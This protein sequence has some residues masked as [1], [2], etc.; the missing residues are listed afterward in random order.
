MMKKLTHRGPDDTG[1]YQSINENIFLGHCRLAVLDIEGGSQPMWS[2]DGDCVIVYNGEIYNHLDIRAELLAK[3]YRF[4]THHSDTE[5]LLNGYLE[6][7][8][9][10]LERLNGMFAFVVYDKRN[11]SFFGARD[12]FGQKPL[13]YAA[14]RDFFAFASELRALIEHPAI[15]PE[16]DRLALKKYFAHD[17]IPA[18]NTI[19]KDVA[20][21]TAGHYFQYSTKEG[22]L[23]T[24]KYW[25]YRIEPEGAFDEKENDEQLRDLLQ[26]SVKDCLLSDV[27]IG[28]LLSGGIDSSTIATLASSVTKVPVR[29]FS[30]GFEEA[31]FDESTH[32]QYLAERIGS[33]HEVSTLSQRRA[34]EILPS[35]LSRLDEPLGDASLLP[36]YLV[37]EHARRFVTVA[38][39]GDG[40]DELFAGYDPFK[41]LYWAKSYFKI[42]PKALHNWLTRTAQW[43]PVSH[44]NMSLAFKI[45]RFLRP[46]QLP[47]HFWAPLWMSAMSIE[48]MEQLFQEPISPEEIFSEAIA[49]WNSC[50]SSNLVDRLT[51]YF[52]Q[53]YLPNNILT[54]VDRASMMNSL[55]VRVP[56]VSRA[57]AAHILPLPVAA[58]YDERAGKALLRQA[59]AGVLPEPVLTRKKQGFT[60]PWRTLFAGSMRDMVRERLLS[61]NMA[62]SG[63]FNMNYLGMMLLDQEEGRRDYANMLFRLLVFSEW[64]EAQT[65]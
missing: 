17:Y 51:T 48:E 42:I 40:A 16:I 12:H 13:Y 50:P 11:R 38:L 49:A 61:Q 25:E 30:V 24:K 2:F 21:L 6:W 56:F 14:R 64:L 23:V 65:V 44:R 4:R 36:T 26:R 43:L 3:G 60:R 37:C 10:V 19:F 47:A 29:T 33:E 9:N 18:P 32:S 7:G 5:T 46:L 35:V 8:T 63:W 53:M 58:H 57:F 28:I 41:A 31:S 62:R 59:M 22:T 20:K 34:I 27:P 45:Q 1:D 52:V 15:R 55:E 39:G 54:K